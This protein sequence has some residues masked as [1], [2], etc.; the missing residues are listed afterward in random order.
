MTLEEEP[1]LMARSPDGKDLL[2]SKR[3][4]SYCSWCVGW[5]SCVELFPSFHDNI[6]YEDM[7]IVACIHIS[8]AYI[9]LSSLSSS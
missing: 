4:A 8:E 5:M 7:A 3:M 9:S 6:F 2:S 1:L